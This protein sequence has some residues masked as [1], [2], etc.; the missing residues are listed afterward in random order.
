MD[1]HRLWQT[2]L[3][4]ARWFQAKGLDPVVRE[5][6]PL[7]WYIDDG[8]CWVRSELAIVHTTAGRETYHLLVGYLPLGQAEPA[9]LV[10]RATLP[11]RGEV[12]VVDAPLSPVAMA[13]CLRGLA[14]APT[15]RMSWY[16]DPPDPASPTHVFSGEQSNTN[17]LIGDTVL[18]KLL[19]KLPGERSLEGDILTTLAG[20]GLAPRLIGTLRSPWT[21]YDLGLFCEQIQDATDGW[22]FATAACARGESIGHAMLELG[23]TLRRLH[24]LLAEAYGVSIID[25]LAVTKLMTTRLD[26]AV[27]QLPELRA[28]RDTLAAAFTRLGTTPL[29]AQ[30]LH[31]DFHLG[32]ALLSPRGWRL[33]DFE[34]EPLKTL[35]ERVA[36]DVVWR[37]V[38]GL[39]R[40]LDYARSR[41]T[42]P[43]SAAADA[44]Y[45][46]ARSH[47][48]RGYRGES[49]APPRILHAYEVDKLIY[50][51]QYELRNRP[52][53]AA[54][55]RRALQAMAVGV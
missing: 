18:L 30:R 44:W 5:V 48:L 26:A 28:L 45:A 4:E 2:Y 52:E 1:A 55:P 37:D 6:R 34:G 43:T 39:T 15:P 47:F 25:P 51:L 7:P 23:H 17:I 35:A 19:R 16:E 53:W 14:V 32:Q 24:F 29:T 33:I 50:E 12:D 36:P 41:H 27:D 21:G 10:G 42:D 46:D 40:S 54:I 31:G 8:D 49:E 20:S 22:E 3:P 9:A 38:A 11:E 13:A